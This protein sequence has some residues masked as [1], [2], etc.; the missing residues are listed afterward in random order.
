MR[1]LYIR[2]LLFVGLA[3]MIVS[4]SGCT[5]EFYLSEKEVQAYSNALASEQSTNLTFDNLQ[6]R[7]ITIQFDNS[8]G[9]PRVQS[10]NLLAEM[11]RTELA[12]L[13]SGSSSVSL[14]RL[15]DELQAQISHW[16]EDRLQLYTSTND[17]ARLSRLDSVTIQ[18]LTNPTFTYHPERQSIAFDLRLRFTINGTVEVNAVNWLINLFANVNGT[19]PLSILIWEMHA[20]GDASMLSPYA[21][22]GRIRFKLTPELVP[23][24]IQLPFP[25]GTIDVPIYV[26]DN[27]SPAPEQVKVGLADF[28]KTR[29]SSPIDEIFDQDYSYFSLV[30]LGLSAANTQTPS[31]L[32]VNY[33]AKA[34]SYGIASETAN[35]LLHIVT[36]ATD[37]RLYHARKIDGGWSSYLPVPFPSPSP[38]PY[39]RI[40]N[41]PTLVHS[42]DGQ[43][44]LAATDAGGDL[45]YAHWRDEAWGNTQIIKP[46]TALN[47]AISY[48]G[49]PAVVATAP[50]QV[51]VIAVGSDGYLW[52]LRRLNGLWLAPVMV[53]HTSIPATPGP[54][55]DPAAAFVGNKVMVVFVDSQNHLQGIAFDVEASLW[56][57]VSPIQTAETIRYASSAVACGDDD[58]GLAYVGQSGTPYSR[59]LGIQA[60]NFVPNVS[61]SG[62]VVTPE[63]TITGGTLNASPILVASGYRRLEIVGRF[64]DNRLWH[65]HFVYA[66][67]PFS[68]DGRTVTPGWQG[69]TLLSGNLPNSA[70]K[71]D[72]AVSDFSVAATPTGRMELAARGFVSYAYST[73][74]IY[75]NNYDATRYGYAPWK[76]VQWRGYDVA[77]SQL[78]LGRPA[79]VA[80]DRNF[81]IG[82]VGNYTPGHGTFLNDANLSDMN[83]TT[84]NVGLGAR[85]TLIS[86]IVMA[87]GPGTFDEI[88][89]ADNGRLHHERRLSTGSGRGADLV[90]PSGLTL[91]SQLSATSYGNAFLELAATLSDG[92]TY[93]WRYRS[94]VWSN[95]S[96]VACHIASSPALTYTGGGQL[97]LLAV[98]LDHKL[99]RWR[100]GGSS[101]AQRLS[102]ASNFFIE[103]RLF[104]TNAASSWGDGTV[105]VV[106]V[107]RTTRALYHR[108]VGPDNEIC[109]LPFGC[110]APR[111]FSNL[112]GNIADKPVLTAFSPTKLNVLTMG[113]LQW[114]SNWATASAF[115]VFP[116]RRDPL[117]DW[118]GFQ[119]IGGSEMVVGSAASSGRLNYA[120]LAIHFSGR[121]YINR[122]E[123]GRWTGFQS[124]NGQTSDMLIPSPLIPPA[125]TAHGA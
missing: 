22:A 21:N 20:Q 54:Y 60:M 36:R 58:V 82:F 75:H 84:V 38:T 49:K 27:G 80:V 104:G 76:T 15:N 45:V 40:D 103:E 39:P 73:R 16:I 87:S 89:V 34:S 119:S 67:A 92:C 57:F 25:L 4:A 9:T 7:T 51:E 5:D 77:G 12:Q 95:P 107:D 52:H 62:Y 11:R 120:A 96:A 94:R 6:G 86:P 98:D 66:P 23:N 32:E 64:S 114:Y 13:E 29:L 70:D 118:S 3:L 74:Y 53:P 44:E 108:R 100:F 10:T 116:P 115:Q 18:F 71:T 122:Y 88:Y 46:N 99:Y 17:S 65:N 69:W 41:E 42:G 37:G 79:L 97:E 93:H 83:S 48:R 124:I 91:A 33:R 101:W 8:T 35:P 72:A 109:T 78:A 63:I 14:S 59:L 121:V 105:D 68:N 43:L 123:N 81:Q 112:G 30:H 110:P 31:R 50:G 111:V 47:P 106:V 19:Y 61:G 90:V 24:T 26:T 28:L 56:G 55:R 102:I 2:S 113:G 125:I 117:I 1:S 85:S